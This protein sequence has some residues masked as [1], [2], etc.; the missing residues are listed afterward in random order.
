MIV[1][2][3]HPNLFR[4]HIGIDICNS[5]HSDHIKSGDISLHEE[6]R[7]HPKLYLQQSSY[8]SK[9]YQLNQ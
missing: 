7:E 1:V 9:T 8:K 4:K 3:L 6:C 2:I 5:G